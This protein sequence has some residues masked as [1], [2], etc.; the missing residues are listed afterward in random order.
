V[1]SAFAAFEPA[2]VVTT[3]LALPAAPAGV[4]DVIVVA[5]TTLNVVAEAPAMVTP[6]APM[7]PVPVMVTPVPPAVGP[8]LGLIAVTVGAA[9]YVN[10][11]LGAF[12][13]VN[14][15]TT[16]LAVPAAPAGVVAVIVVALTTLTPVAAVPPIVTPVAPVKPVPVI[17]TLVPPVVGPL[18][19]AIAVTVGAAT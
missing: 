18:A 13:P 17:V 1:N 19:G 3:T 7:K 14:V 12:E 8:A 9:T 6:V 4:V 5:L 11:V 10:N 2:G 15:G 16:T